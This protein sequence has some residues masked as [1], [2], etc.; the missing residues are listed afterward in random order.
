[1]PLDIMSTLKES[2]I[3]A[4]FNQQMVPEQVR[5]LTGRGVAVEQRELFNLQEDPWEH[6]NL[7]DEKPEIVSNYQ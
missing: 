2:I 1:M 3:Y 5:E 6:T 4:D 7:T